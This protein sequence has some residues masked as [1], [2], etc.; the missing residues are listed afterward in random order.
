MAEGDADRPIKLDADY[1]RRL[2]PR[3]DPGGHKFDFGRLVIVAGSLDYAGAALMTAMAAV[4]GGAGLVVIAVP[5][6][7]R[8]V[9]AGRVPE[10]ILV[11][12]SDDG[13][14][15]VQP[16]M[17]VSEVLN[18]REPDALVVGPGLKE[19]AATAALVRGLIAVAAVP[20]VIDAGALNVLGTT[21]G[22]WRD[23]RGS[24]VL[25]PHG[26]E[27]SR[28]TGESPGSTD[29]ERLT[30]AS[31]AAARFAQVIVLKGPR[32]VAA[33]AE[34]RA[35]VAPFANPALATA[36]SGDVLAGVIGALL[37]QGVAPFDAACLGVWLHGRAG[38]R[39]SERFGDAG[40]A[41]TDLPVEVALARHELGG[42]PA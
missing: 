34:G 38:E 28:L 2:L 25:T 42:L 7:L 26:G 3:R 1:C 8:P 6:S 5:S 22:W 21:D 39:L 20:A 18:E 12:L 30:A 13:H 41:A 36:G 19:T 29:D 23:A 9:F 11:G 10:A 35:A 32:T 37:A 17:A 4:R 14:G 15:E 24:L 16:D 27:F 33:A 40:V 31:R